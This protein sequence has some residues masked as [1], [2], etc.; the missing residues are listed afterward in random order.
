M[1]IGKLI[2]EVE[3]VCLIES[4]AT[5]HKRKVWPFCSF[6]NFVNFIF[7]CL[8]NRKSNYSYHDVISAVTMDTKT[9]V[10]TTD[11]EVGMDASFRLV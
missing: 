4:H 10:I 6:C 7:D 2:L 3:H 11:D 5:L 1:Y 9:E 8:K